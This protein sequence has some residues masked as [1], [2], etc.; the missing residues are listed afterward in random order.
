MSSMDA[1]PVLSTPSNLI[2]IHSISAIP[3]GTAQQSV[4]VNQ[5]VQV[6]QLRENLKKSVINII[7]KLSIKQLTWLE[8]SIT[9]SIIKKR[10]EMA[11]IF[12]TTGTARL[13]FY[14]IHLHMEERVDTQF[15]LLSGSCG[16]KITH[17]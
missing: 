6:H 9:T 11:V 12:P 2:L 3:I 17:Q 4:D 8:S 1:L 15:N 7:D 5:V 13:L 10:I 16:I 14:T